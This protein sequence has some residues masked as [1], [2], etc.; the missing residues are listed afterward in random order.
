MPITHKTSDFD[1][2]N[3]ATVDIDITPSS[4][5]N[6]KFYEAPRSYWLYALKL[7]N[8]KYY[9]GYTGKANPY[10]RIMQHVV[11]E[12]GAQWTKKQTYAS[13]SS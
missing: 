7:K 1:L 4:I 10:D 9:V 13:W 5:T 11:G 2:I 3:P 12:D 6:S 8:N